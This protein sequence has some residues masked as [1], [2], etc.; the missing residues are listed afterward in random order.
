PAARV[1]SLVPS[2]T[3]LLFVLG[4]GAGV[5]GVTRYCTEP[6]E[7]VRTLTK[8]GGTKNPDVGAI[9][10]LRPDLVI[11]N[12]EEN[13][14][15][16]FEALLQ[17]GLT[18]F[19]SF[20]RTVVQVAALMRRLASLVGME[21]TGEALA[22]EI[23]SAV[24]EIQQRRP[25][26]GVR[27]RR[28]FCPI[29]KNP[30]MVFNRDTYNDDLLCQAGGENLFRGLPERYSRVEIEAVARL[31][32]QVILL[33]DE[34]YA[35]S[36]KDLESLDGLDGTPARH[37]G[38]VHFVDGKALSWYGPRTVEALRQFKKLLDGGW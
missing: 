31:Q 22:G 11:V 12:A 1:V 5:V 36:A 9:V 3:E 33:P 23:E 14:R 34:P 6:R 7:S 20:T 15:Q 21:P 16:D 13:R 27:P 17:H 30:W 32:P 2:L 18:V 26:H 8:V 19:V 4:G 29:W 37:D 38:R 25:A 10:A 24:H 28:V 35:F